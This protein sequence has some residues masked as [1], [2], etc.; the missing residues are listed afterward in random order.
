MCYTTRAGERF[1]TVYQSCVQRCV[2][3]ATSACGEVLYSGSASSSWCTAK[4]IKSEAKAYIATGQFEAQRQCR[5][6]RTRTNATWY[7]A[8]CRPHLFKPLTMHHFCNNHH[9]LRNLK[10]WQFILAKRPHSR[11]EFPDR[12]GCPQLDHCSH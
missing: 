4:T 10:F 3:A 5:L 11:S 6:F 2:S 1:A 8:L 12:F 7:A 9:F